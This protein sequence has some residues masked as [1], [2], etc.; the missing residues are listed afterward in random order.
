MLLILNFFQTKTLLR[1]EYIS[2]VFYRG[3]RGHMGSGSKTFIVKYIDI[4]L[5]VLFL[6]INCITIIDLLSGIILKCLKMY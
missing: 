3:S 4:I 5:L 6:H 1:S 2:K